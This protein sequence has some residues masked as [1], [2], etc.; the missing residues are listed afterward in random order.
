MKSNSIRTSGPSLLKARGVVDAGISEAC[1]ILLLDMTIKYRPPL[2]VIPHL[3][4]DDHHS[5]GT[6]S[7]AGLYVWI[8]PSL[9][10][11]MS[12]TKETRK[13]GWWSYCSL[14]ARQS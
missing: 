10:C 8:A 6:H 14:A 2:T 11:L 12:H 7:T 4:A 3:M 13:C 9:E 5:H 1:R